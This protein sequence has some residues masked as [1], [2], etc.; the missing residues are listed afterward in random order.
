MTESIVRASRGGMKRMKPQI[1]GNGL[2]KEDAPLSENQY[3]GQV[4][5]VIHR[6]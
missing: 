5:V 3:G 4:R 2:K 6:Q 1:Q